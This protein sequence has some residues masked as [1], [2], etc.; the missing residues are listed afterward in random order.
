MCADPAAFAESV[1]LMEKH[2]ADM[3]HV[4]LMDGHYVSNIVLDLD[5]PKRLRALTGLPLDIHLMHESTEELLEKL[6]TRPGDQLMFHLGT[7]RQPWRVAQAI[8]ARGCR[9]GLVLAAETPLARVE[10]LLGAFDFVNLMSV[11]AGMAGG[12]FQ[13]SA[14][15]KVVRLKELLRRQGREMPV[16]LDG[17]IGF[18]N[19]EKVLDA[20]VDVLIL[21]YAACFNKDLGTDT[22]LAESKRI[23]ADWEYRNNSGR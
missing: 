14:L 9:A 5:L 18:Q 15:S 7:T 19:M 23:I 8:H 12:P 4:D 2:G 20:G 22:A 3:I 13:W 10:E 21:G 1:A 17:S 6:E 16:Q 11:P